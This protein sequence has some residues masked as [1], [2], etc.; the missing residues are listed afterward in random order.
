MQPHFTNL[1]ETIRKVRLYKPVKSTM[2]Q[3]HRNE[4]TSLVAKTRLSK[5]RNLRNPPSSNVNKREKQ[6]TQN[7]HFLCS[8]EQV[9]REVDEFRIIY[10]PS[11]LPGVATTGDRYPVDVQLAKSH[12]LLVS[13][14]LFSERV[15]KPWRSLHHF[16]DQSS[17]FN[18]ILASLQTTRFLCGLELDIELEVELLAGHRAL[19]TD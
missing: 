7:T 11:Y 10:L 4:K 18:E 14:P 6:D 16:S 8:L 2:N 9:K 1:L 13:R 15:L 5:K 17:V 3:S 19:H 12:N